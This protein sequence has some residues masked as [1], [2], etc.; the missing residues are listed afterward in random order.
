MIQNGP[1]FMQPPLAAAAAV[2][3]CIKCF[4]EITTQSRCQPVGLCNSKVK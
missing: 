4:G 1:I 2:T 3:Y